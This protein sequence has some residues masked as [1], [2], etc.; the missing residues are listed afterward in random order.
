MDEDGTILWENRPDTAQNCKVQ[1]PFPGSQFK[2]VAVYESGGGANLVIKAAAA[3]I[4]GTVLSFDIPV[5]GSADS[6]TMLF[7]NGDGFTVRNVPG[8]LVATAG[9]TQ[10]TTVGY[11]RVQAG[12]GSANMAG[13]AI[14][15]FR[16]NGVLVT[17]AGVQ[18]SAAMDSGRIFAEVS[19]PS[20]NTGVAI[21]NPAAQDAVVSFYF[22]D[23]AG[24]NS[25]QGQIIV[26]AHGQ[27]ARFL[28]QDPFLIGSS[29]IG[30]FTFTSSV[31]AGIT[32]LHGL[33]NERSE[34]LITTLPVVPLSSVSTQPLL[35]PDYADGG[36]WTGAHH[37]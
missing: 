11:A 34:F 22:T 25:H 16:Q 30:T 37:A 5:T 4:G 10:P 27:I 26:P 14:F 17:E 6:S 20:I 19:T 28:D 24:Q 7:R 29:F 8:T 15:G 12:A 32:A 3:C 18:A 33:L 9:V 31:P 13:V 1:A 36:G 2:S 23:S 35:F 21:A